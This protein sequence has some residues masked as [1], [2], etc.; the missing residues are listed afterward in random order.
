MQSPSQPI[1]ANRP[2]CSQTHPTM[3]A[4]A[5]LNWTKILSKCSPSVRKTI[6]ETRSHHEDLRR[7]ISELHSTLPKLDF[8]AY[9]QVLPKEMGK[10]VDEAEKQFKAFKTEKVDVSGQLKELEQERELKVN[11]SVGYSK[12]IVLLRF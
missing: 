7:Q 8:A 11:K 1:R 4:P 12:V 5:A 10:V 6:L 9:R 3:S 2:C